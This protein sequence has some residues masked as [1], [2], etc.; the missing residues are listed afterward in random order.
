MQAIGYKG[1]RRSWAGYQK[2]KNWKAQISII[3][4]ISLQQLEAKFNE[5]HDDVIFKKKS[6]T[7]KQTK[8]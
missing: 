6:K 8:I 3:F 4:H 1:G 2:K 5:S 7:D